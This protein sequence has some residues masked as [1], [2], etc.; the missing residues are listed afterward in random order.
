MQNSQVLT[1]ITNELILV[2]HSAR[3]MECVRRTMRWCGARTPPL[4]SAEMASSRSASIGSGPAPAI[5]TVGCTASSCASNASK[6]GRRREATATSQLGG[7]MA[8][9]GVV[10]SGKGAAATPV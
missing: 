2:I 5:S 1:I 10:A 6:H 7:C 4:C 8:A 9:F 3:H